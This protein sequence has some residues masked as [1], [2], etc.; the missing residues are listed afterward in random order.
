MAYAQ[1]VEDVDKIAMA[2]KSMDRP[3]AAEVLRIREQQFPALKKIADSS[4]D[5][6]FVNKAYMFEHYSR[7]L[8]ALI[9]DGALHDHSDARAQLQKDLHYRRYMNDHHRDNHQHNH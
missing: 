4:H 3:L 7:E 8:A 6:D 9:E 1:L 5:Q 2:V